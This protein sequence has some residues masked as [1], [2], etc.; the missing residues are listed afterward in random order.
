MPTSEVGVIPSCSP[1]HHWTSF[2]LS[3]PPTSPHLHGLSLNPDPLPL[4]LGLLCS[5]FSVSS[6]VP[7]DSPLHSSSGDLLRVKNQSCLPPW[8]KAFCFSPHPPDRAHSPAHGFQVHSGF[9]PGCP[10]PDALSRAVPGASAQ[11]FRLHRRGLGTLSSLLFLTKSTPTA[12]TKGSYS[13]VCLPLLSTHP[14][15]P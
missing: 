11:A 9:T 8:L 15:G 1:R 13:S 5:G 10:Y 2:C 3:D 12:C 4:P 6:L 7:S 14:T